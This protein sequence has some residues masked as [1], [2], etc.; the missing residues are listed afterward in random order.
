[1][2]VPYSRTFR[3]LFDFYLNFLFRRNF[4][5]IHVQVDKI[6]TEC[7]HTAAPILALDKNLPTLLVANHCSWWDGFFLARLQREIAPTGILLT[8]MLESELRK[9]PLFRKL[10]AVGLDPK[11]PVSVAR[12]FCKLK[13]F[14]KQQSRPV[15]IAYFPQGEIR[16]QFEPT[17]SFKPGVEL[18]IRMLRPLQLIPVALAIEPMTASKPSG[19]ILAGKAQFVDSNSEVTGESLENLVDRL[20]RIER[21]RLVRHYLEG[22]LS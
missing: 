13:E 2:K 19:F 12:A 11:N 20:L 10:G 1:M 14:T 18:L 22:A 6:S 15:I 7:A 17:L 21:P 4:E 16:P 5:R 8:V 3:W 9:Y